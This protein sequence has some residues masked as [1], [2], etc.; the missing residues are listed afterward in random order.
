MIRQVE[1]FRDKYGCYPESVHADQIYRTR[2]NLK[3]CRERNI[4]LSGARLG[5][6]P[7][8]TE[9][10][11]T[12]LETV[13]RLARQDELDRIE[14]ESKFGQAKRRFSLNRIVTKLAVT[15]EC[16]IALTVL[17][18]NLEKW[19]K[20]V[21]LRLFYKQLKVF[22][23]GDYFNA[24]GD[25]M[26][27]SASR[28]TD[29]P[30]FYSAWFM[31]KIRAGYVLCRNPRNERQVSRIGL[32][33]ELVDGI[34]FWTKNPR[35]LMPYL[36]ELN[37]YTYY[38]Q[39]TLTA[40][41]HTL[42]TQVPPARKVAETVKELSELIGP[43]KVIWR[44]DPIFF[45]PNYDFSR[46]VENFGTLA[47]VLRGYSTRCVISFLDVYRKCGE[48]LR[49]IDFSVPNREEVYQLSGAIAALAREYGFSVESCAEKYDLSASGIR[50]GKCID[51]ELIAKL[52]GRPLKVKKDRN[53]RPECGC[54]SSVDIGVYNSC[55]HGCLYCYANRNRRRAQ[56]VFR[57]HHPSSAFIDGN[58][59]AGVVIGPFG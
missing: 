8:I 15:S 19:M 3:Y 25:I 36:P 37:A 35:N 30:A 39:I 44:Y 26:I 16:T 21:F 33:P 56:E 1:K 34:V 58:P 32:S 6:P 2:E 57:N 55:P 52:S 14:I 59:A 9:A 38:F 18:M 20:S 42:E 10:N 12:E 27:I 23:S 22:F 11:R 53:Q 54:A 24:K 13:K 17:V 7:K 28:R 5:R 29:I 46:H 31:D 49:G 4:R 50:H 43:E 41:D 47:A 48:N 51:A 40:Y 45:T